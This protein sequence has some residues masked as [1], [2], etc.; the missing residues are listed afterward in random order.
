[1]NVG[2][3]VRQIRGQSRMIGVVVVPPKSRLGDSTAT[4]TGIL[5]PD[6]NS[7]V[8]Y[9]STVWLEIVYEDR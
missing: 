3:L 5:W 6:G 4:M 7:G 1:M 9:H 8:Y 2:D